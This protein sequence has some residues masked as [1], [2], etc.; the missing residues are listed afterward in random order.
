[1]PRAKQY[2][3]SN[4]MWSNVAY[5]DQWQKVMAVFDDR[6]NLRA[7]V[8]HIDYGTY[9]VLLIGDDTEIL[10]Y[11]ND[12]ELGATGKNMDACFKIYCR[13]QYLDA[14]YYIPTYRR[15]EQVQLYQIFPHTRASAMRTGGFR[16]TTDDLSEII[17]M[18]L[19]RYDE[20]TSGDVETFDLVEYD[21]CGG[22]PDTIFGEGGEKMFHVGDG[23][24]CDDD[25][26][27]WEFL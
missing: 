26:D 2:S 19:N 16:V 15:T 22:Y 14:P 20:I 24:Y 3:K 12:I 6:K 8:K 18:A 17:T 27:N 1:M 4:M 11:L 7:V 5:V 25:G 21:D 10:Y 9:G 13:L 23:A